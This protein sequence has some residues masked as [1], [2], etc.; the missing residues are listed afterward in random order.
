[1]NKS[2]RDSTFRILYAASRYENKIRRKASSTPK[3]R[4]VNRLFIILVPFPFLISLFIVAS[5]HFFDTLK[6]LNEVGLVSLLL[7][8]IGAFLY[9][10]FSAWIHRKSFLSALRHPFGLILQNAVVTAEIDSRYIN[11]LT[12]K[13]LEN[14]ELI[15]LEI[16]AEKESFERRISLLIGS[17]DKFGLLPGLIAAFVSLQN[18]SK[19]QSELFLAL[20]YATPILYIFG[21]LS[22][23][24]V[25]RLDRMAKLIELVITR[26]KLLPAKNKT[27][28]WPKRR[29]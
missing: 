22:H 12:K 8:Y 15:C 29:L 23:F 18:I 3:T 4:L 10:L 26:K 24:L 17:I 27:N 28:N 21:A 5:I 9:P 16:R 20:A 19:N 14:L 6:W 1:M 13:P 25:M 11:K 7:T 2:S